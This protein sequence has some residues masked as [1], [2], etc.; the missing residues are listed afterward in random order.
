ME[1]RQLEEEIASL[2]QQLKE[3]E[4]EVADL[5]KWLDFYGIE[6]TEVNGDVATKFK[7]SNMEK[8]RKTQ[9]DTEYAA[10]RERLGDA[11]GVI[12][13]AARTRATFVTIPLYQA[14][15]ARYSK[16]EKE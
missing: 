10:L 5:K 2:R 11:E 12:D 16:G 13:E 7:S 4:D 3:A 9:N 8:F 6:L 1:A 14:Y 15:R